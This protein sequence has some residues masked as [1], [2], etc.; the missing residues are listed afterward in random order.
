[1]LEKSIFPGGEPERLMGDPFMWRSAKYEDIYLQ[2]YG[3]GLSAG[4]KYWNP[5]KRE[6]EDGQCPARLVLAF[7]NGFRAHSERP[8][9]KNNDDSRPGKFILFSALSGLKD[10]VHLNTTE[11]RC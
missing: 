2:D 4:G 10:G 3:D 1:M 8:T 5:I 11:R 9:N 7:P 6:R